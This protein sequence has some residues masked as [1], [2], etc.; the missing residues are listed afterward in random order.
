MSWS[1]VDYGEEEFCCQSKGNSGWGPGGCEHEGRDRSYD[2]DPQPQPRYDHPVRVDNTWPDW[3]VCHLTGLRIYPTEAAAAQ[4]MIQ[5]EA[6][7]ERRGNT[8]RP[9]VAERCGDE[10]WHLR[11]A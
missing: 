5:V 7:C 6:W 1:T 11:C 2:N 4:G 8:F 3:G 9:L 10:H